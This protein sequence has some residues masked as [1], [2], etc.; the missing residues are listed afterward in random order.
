[1]SW[2]YAY[3]RDLVYWKVA[4]EPSMQPAGDRDSCGVFTGCTWPTNLNGT[5]DGSI[6]CF[7]TS[8]QR[9]PIHWTLE[10]HRGSELVRAATSDDHGRTWRHNSVRTLVPGPPNG[11][12]VTGWRDPFIGRWPSLDKHLRQ[13]LD[14][15]MYG[16]LAGG[17]RGQS[18][19]VFLYSI[20][21]WDFTRW[22]YLGTLLTP[23]LNFAPSERLPDFGTNWE[24]TNFMTLQDNFGEPHNVLVMS[25]EGLSWQGPNLPAEYLIDRGRRRPSKSKRSDHM[26]NWMCGRIV[27]STE[28]THGQINVNEGGHRASPVTFE[29]QFG[30]CLDFGCYYAAN[31]FHDPITN[32]RIVHGWVMEEDLPL[33]LAAKQQWSGLLAVPRVLGIRSIRNVVAS[34]GCQDLSA[35][36]WIH[37]SPALDEAY[38]VTFLTCSPDSRLSAL[39]HRE[40]RLPNVP[41]ALDPASQDQGGGSLLSLEAKQFG[42]SGV[43]LS[44]RCLTTYRPHHLPL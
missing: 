4:P 32:A 9:L 34:S 2:G 30:G 13:G 12:D 26:Q 39:R 18:P 43:F 23:G 14:D 10:Y 31:S 3:S 15:G 21:N 38:T 6:T 1:M 28:P 27:Q 22:D 29:F 35:L 36:D 40:K 41:V 17:I 5:T 25:V 8:A 20:D 24:V 11:L 42:S 33:S 44:L 19:A 16:V 37:C 7:Y